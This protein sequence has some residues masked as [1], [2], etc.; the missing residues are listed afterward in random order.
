MSGLMAV[1][2]KE[3]ADNFNSLRFVTLSFL[4]YIAGVLLIV[5]V[6]AQNIR[7]SV[8]E[9]T[10]FIFLRLFTVS[11]DIQLFSFPFFMSF[12]IPILGIVLG[13][14]AVNSERTSGNLSRVLSQPIH[15]DTVINGKFMAGLAT[16]SILVISIVFLMSGI[17]L[18][19]IGVP[20]GPDEI[21][22]LFAFIFVTI[23]YGAFWL[24]LA[25]LFS[26]YCRRI[27]TSA[28][29]SIA[30]WIFIFFFMSI[31]ASLVA[32]IIVP[33][34]QNSTE[35]LQ[36]HHGEVAHMISL[37]SPAMLYNES[38][39]VILIPSHPVMFLL[40]IYFSGLEPDPLSLSQSLLIAWPQIVSLVALT[41]LCF[42]G[43]Y[44]KFMREEIR[45][46]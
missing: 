1:F 35:A 5:F 43:S 9:T 11:G 40:S 21:L 34:D 19:M 25:I 20:P 38:I 10:E 45:S 17:G 2:R 32:T 37:I 7:G 16:I 24:A 30:V 18:R 44:I 22:R 46:T 41:A 12:F 4:M 42:A 6:A 14:D 27:A 36:I 29:A 15:R 31:V 39:Q 23:I 28:L 13:F 3:L 8:T 26:V 33:I